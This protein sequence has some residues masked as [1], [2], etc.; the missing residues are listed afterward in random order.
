MLTKQDAELVMRVGPGT[1]MGELIRRTWL[2]FCLSEELPAADCDP[3]HIRLMHEDLVAFRDSAGRV[4]VVGEHCPHRNASLFYGRNEE[5]GLRC[6]YHGWKIDVNGA[7]LETPCEPPESRM[8]FHIRHTAYAVVE[9]GD[10]VWI[11]MGPR[12]KEPPFPN[13]SWTRLPAENRCVGKVNYACNYVQSI[14]GAIEHIHGDV[15]HSGH[16][17]MGWTPEQITA[18][19]RAYY[20]FRPAARHYE[21]QDTAY[22]FRSAGIKPMDDD[23]QGVNVTPFIVPFHVMLAGSPHMF[24]PID[25]ENT[26]YF[27]VRAN[28]SRPIDRA[29]A[30]A[31]RGEVV[32]VDVDS[33]RKKLR[34]L[35]NNFM[36]DRR[37]MREKEEHWSFSG[38]PWGKP[39][40]DMLMIET[41]GPLTDWTTE[42]LGQADVVVAHM[43]Q[44]MIDAVRR[45]MQTGEVAE[46]DASVPLDCVRGGGGVIP[47]EVP[48]QSVAAFAGEGASSPVATD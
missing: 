20:G 30:L 17:L 45:F 43:R 27:D 6:L 38:I 44:R 34:T 15:L 42:H 2:P 4:G 32:G 24:V 40:Q 41:M 36:Q 26:W 3:I 5:G 39:H 11:Y 14:E 22:G 8:R 9:R 18:L 31:E 35:E 13:F 16:E 12:D 33:E 19:D 10:V 46:V 28:P 37:A 47:N 23:Q 7:I 29:K 1:P 21:F 48:W 25:D